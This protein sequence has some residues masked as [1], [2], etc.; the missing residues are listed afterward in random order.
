MF[1][2]IYGRVMHNL[3]A[4]N[5]IVLVHNFHESTGLMKRRTWDTVRLHCY[6]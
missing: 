6:R 4:L 3:D 1:N 2:N 5:V